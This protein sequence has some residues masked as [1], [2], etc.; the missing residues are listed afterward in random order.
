M[1]PDECFYTVRE[2][3]I[4]LRVRAKPGAR[5]DRVA[6]VRGGS[7]VVEVRA[8][9][10]HGKANDAVIKALADALCIKA[11]AIALKTGHAAPRKLFILP[12]AARPALERLAK[13]LS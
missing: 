6:A 3:D 1:K 2:R 4:M 13:E 7:L 5:V 8:A 10:E 11:S 12:H 9:P